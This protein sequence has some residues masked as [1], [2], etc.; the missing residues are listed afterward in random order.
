MVAVRLL[1]ATKRAPT[2]T[3]GSSAVER[4]FDVTVETT[5][6]LRA[7][8]VAVVWTEDGWHSTHHTECALTQSDLDRDVWAGG[9]SFFTN[10]PT[11]F[12]YALAAAFPDAVHWDNNGGWN[13]LI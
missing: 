12:F 1:S 9:I 8:R 13:Y 3:P 10:P 6:G 7:Y 2:G 5:P 4:G 11:T